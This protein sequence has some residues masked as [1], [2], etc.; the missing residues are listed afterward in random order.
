VSP[1]E[2]VARLGLTESDSVDPDLLE[3]LGMLRVLDDG[4]WQIL[5]PAAFQAA[6]ELASLGVPL[7]RRVEVTRLL[8][9]HTHAMA[10]AVVELFV[11]DLWR[12][13]SG[14][15]DDPARWEQLTT[16]VARLR[17]L[18]SATVAGFFD[19]A[20]SQEAEKATERE[21]G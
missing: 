21:L 5:S 2:G 18:A 12:P 8:Q 6:R 20:L 9:E 19:A 3:E 13:P 17:P 11:K 15:I 1:A 10:Q 4:R 16:A 7:H 14:T